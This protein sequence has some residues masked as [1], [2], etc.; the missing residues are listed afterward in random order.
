[1]HS[2]IQLLN[3]YGYVILFL[4]L[5]LE[6][7]AFPLPNELLMSYVGYLVFK[8]EMNWLAAMAAGI[9]GCIAGVTI[10]YWIGRKLGAPFFHKYGY[11]FHLGP[12]RLDKFSRAFNLY[13]KR[14]LLF[15]AFIPGVR[16]LT[17]YSAGITRVPFRSYTFFSYIGAVIW[18]G[19]FVTL[20]K[21]LG[22][23]YKLIE[24]AAKEYVLIL[25]VA[26][27]VIVVFYYI[28]KYNLAA[29]KSAL[30][31]IFRSL[32]MNIN[33][34]M[35]TRLKL[36]I[37][38]SAIAFSILNSLMFILLDEYF[39]QKSVSFNQNVLVI[40]NAMF[41]ASWDHVMAASLALSTPTAIAVV[42]CLTF[43]WIWLKG[44]NRELEI[45]MLFVMVA[46]GLIF[47]TY[48]PLLIEHVML[49]AGLLFLSSGSQLE[50][51]SRLIMSFIM[52]GYM[53]FLVSRHVRKY[54]LKIMINILGFC[55]LITTGVGY[56]YFRYQMPSDLLTDYILSGIWLSFIIMC[57]E[58]WRLIIV[59]NLSSRARSRREKTHRY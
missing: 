22:P 51:D 15:S 7:L 41:P 57:L 55:L 32:F 24:T 53:S 28:V 23:K 8:G 27:A 43:I 58:T 31:V 35:R 50:P 59:S 48:L 33:F 6:M 2:M 36:L 37:A 26:I 17:G 3:D 34:R 19:T 39:H 16:H 44:K 18:V 42:G 11:R 21:I 52:Y 29:I 12:E 46:G 49:R 20:G 14:L 47:V 54:R 38:G 45:Q 5:T 10:T 40:F 4:S 1:M 56:L 25:I 9:S 30:I 13:G